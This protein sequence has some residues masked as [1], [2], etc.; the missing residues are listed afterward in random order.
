MDKFEIIYD[1]DDLVEILEFLTI[2]FSWNQEKTFSFGLK[3]RNN[4]PDFP[5]AAATSKGGKLTAA[6]LLIAQQ[7]PDKVGKNKILN[8]SGWY[9]LPEHRG[10]EAVYFIKK[11]VSA[12]SA[13]TLTDYTPSKAATVVLKALGFKG[14]KAEKFTFGYSQGFKIRNEI[15]RVINSFSEGGLSLSHNLSKRLNIRNLT[16][17][18]VIAFYWVTVAKRGFL[19]ARFLN[20]YIETPSRFARPTL[21]SLIGLMI[22][23]R[24]ISINLYLACSDRELVS[25]NHPWLIKSNEPNLTVIPPIDSELVVL[26]EPS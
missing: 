8:L 16:A 19:R 17:S 13:Y 26:S 23:Y 22:R 3:V 24:A 2:G 11:L 7:L 20:V 12:L 14:M 21:F 9:A 6:V 18:N 4:P 10:V 25:D 15:V 1:R 5:I